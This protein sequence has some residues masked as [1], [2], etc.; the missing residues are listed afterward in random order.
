MTTLTLTSRLY[1]E[2]EAL[3]QAHRNLACD[4]R[5]ESERLLKSAAEHEKVGEALQEIRE[6]R[7]HKAGDEGYAVPLLFAFSTALKQA[8]RDLDDGEL[9]F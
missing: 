3:E 6:S 2:I 5:E 1:R 4:A 7:P 9:P 8:E